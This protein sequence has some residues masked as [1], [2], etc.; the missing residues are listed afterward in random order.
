MLRR[1]KEQVAPELPSKL[2]VDELCDLSDEQWRVYREVMAE[3]RK[4]VGSSRD[5]GQAG[6]ARIRMLTALLRLRQ[7][8][9]DLSL[10]GNERLSA[11]ALPRRSA[12]L[13]RLLEL[14]EEAL[15][16]GHR[17]LVFSQ[18]RSQLDEIGKQL[19]ARGWGYLQL[20]GRTRK[21]QERVDRF[22]R[23]DG[24]PVFLISLKAGGYGLNLTA[25]D[26]VVHFD[27]WWNPAAE[28]Q[29]TDRAH[30]IGQTRPVTVY[31]LISRGTVE[32]KVLALQARKRALASAIDEAGAADAANWSEAELVRLLEDA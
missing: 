24:P 29:A 22:Q 4:L 30:R 7:T 21:R 2:F 11:L 18:F 23:A 5:A 17:V 26:T 20:D 6:A 9:C 14:L 16:G 15:A 1:T 32:E 8:C 10:L 3:G 25:A 13:Q 31:R 19:D 28:A 27:P 12:K